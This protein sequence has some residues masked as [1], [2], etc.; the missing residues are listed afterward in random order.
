MNQLYREPTHPTCAPNETKY[1]R[2]EQAEH[3]V[4]MRMEW[5]NTPSTFAR[6]D[7]PVNRLPSIRDI[8]GM[9][10]APISLAAFI[11]SDIAIVAMKPAI[12]AAHHT[13]SDT[14]S[15]LD[16]PPFWDDPTAT[17]PPRRATFQ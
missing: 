1:E 8:A 9:S 16:P 6:F 11:M 15:P 13:N 10:V 14:I 3:N 7:A 4:P 2:V 5:P 17:H 12:N